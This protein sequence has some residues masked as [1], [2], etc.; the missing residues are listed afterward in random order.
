MQ[1]GWGGS[2]PDKE[3]QNSNFF[4]KVG[5]ATALI[6]HSSAGENGE[7]PS[8]TKGDIEL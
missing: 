2:S 1:I 6:L 4:A 3:S 5:Y 7:E 8:W